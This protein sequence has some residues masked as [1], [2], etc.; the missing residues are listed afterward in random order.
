M[1]K[2]PGTFPL[3]PTRRA[4]GVLAGLALGVALLAG[5]SS[6]GADTDCSIA[7]SCTI[8]FQRGVDA[9]ASILGVEAKLVGVQDE[10]VTVEVAG[11]QVTLLTGQQAAEVAG[12]AV[13]LDSVTDQEIKI[14]VSQGGGS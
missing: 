2:R 9:S 4:A 14:R 10:Q 11:E 3:T 7:G 6:E 13:T 5:C 12:F 8:T 1:T